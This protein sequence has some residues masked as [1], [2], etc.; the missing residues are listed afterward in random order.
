MKILMTEFVTHDVKRFIVEK[1]NGYSFIPGQATLLS[2]DNEELKNEERPFTFTSLNEDLVLEFIIK[3]YP[4]HHGITEKL[5]QLKPGDRLI[6][7]EPWGTINY[8]DSG[9]FLAGGAGIT[10]FI[11]IF[12]DLQKK[13]RLKGNKLI[14]TNKTS[15]DIIL[16]QELK[17]MFGDD[18]TLILT[19]E[20]NPYYE[21]GVLNE[22]YIKNN[23][24]DFNQNFYLCGPDPF[25]DSMKTILAKFGAQ[26]D[27]MV[28]E[29]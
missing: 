19:E 5:H 9:T 17:Y 20:K 2:I 1:P 7:R 29:K 24:T 23:I 15:R 6:V 28:F 27:N 16:E 21:F 4:Q 10:P 25:V 26:P 11:A 8:K 18:L 14:F 13:N 22:D 12:R 3:G